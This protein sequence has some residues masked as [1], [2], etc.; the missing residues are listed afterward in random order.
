MVH[1]VILW[2]LKPE[3]EGE[4]KQQV[5]RGIKEGLEG[6][7]TVLPGVVDIKVNIGNRLDSANCDLMLDSSFE[8]E[9]YLKNYSRSPEHLAVAN[10]KVR[11]YTVQRVCFDWQD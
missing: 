8:T 6:L 10:G 11:P 7:K 2:T 3:L 5:L 9:A 1:H 4:E